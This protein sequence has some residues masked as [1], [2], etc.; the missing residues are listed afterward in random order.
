MEALITQGVANSS[1]LGI[2]V[3]FVYIF[4]QGQICVI[5][6]LLQQAKDIFMQ[7]ANEIKQLRETVAELKG[8]LKYRRTSNE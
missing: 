2:I 1:F 7:V 3:L 5:Y 4:L 6:W 8:E